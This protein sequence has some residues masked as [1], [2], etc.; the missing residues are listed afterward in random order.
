[1]KTVKIITHSS[2]Q[3]SFYKPE[4]KKMSFKR[5]ISLYFL[6]LYLHLFKGWS[7]D[8]DNFRKADYHD[9]EYCIRNKIYNLYRFESTGHNGYYRPLFGMH[10]MYKWLFKMVCTYPDPYLKDVADKN[11]KSGYYIRRKIK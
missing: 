5:K 10:K 9:F 6:K 4:N 2:T 8:I 7:F 11:K 1:M 3:P